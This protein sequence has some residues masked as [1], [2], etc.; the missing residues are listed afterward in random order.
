MR[1]LQW[2]LLRPLLNAPL[3]TVR[4]LRRP[5]AAWGLLCGVAAGGAL[6]V[7]W[8]PANTLDWQPGRAVAEPWRAFTAAWVH[9]SP[10]HL[11]ANLLGTVVVAALGWAARLPAAAALAW[12]LAWPLGHAALAWQPVL[13][14]YGGLSGVLHAGVGVA[15][16]WL[17]LPQPRPGPDSHRVIGGAI[18]AGL[19]LKL[20]L[21]QPWGAPLREGGGW[22]IAVVPL[23]H[24]TGAAAGAGC[25]LLAGLAVRSAG[26]QAGRPSIRPSVPAP[27]P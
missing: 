1:R 12:L 23:A 22:D 4:A 16:L 8:L 19:L 5:A 3:R 9:W 24:A 14:H 11:G 27:P 25:A 13:V 10:L 21:E 2:L 26:R 6:L 20:L 18:L 17:L 15:G 7:W